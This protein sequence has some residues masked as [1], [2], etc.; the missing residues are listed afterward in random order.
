VSSIRIWAIEK[1]GSNGQR[2][3]YYGTSY[4]YESPGKP[5]RRRQHGS[6]NNRCANR[7]YGF[8][9]SNG[10]CSF[11]NNKRYHDSVGYKAICG[12]KRNGSHTYRKYAGSNSTIPAFYAA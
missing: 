1:Q 10:N 9:V 8:L 5:P 4:N 11:K 7:Q 2:K 6:C 3:S 12:C